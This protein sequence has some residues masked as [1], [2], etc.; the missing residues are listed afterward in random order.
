MKIF[1]FIV[2]IFVLVG[3]S[4]NSFKNDKIEGTIHFS[5]DD[6]NAVFK[7]LTNNKDKYNSLF[8]QSFFRYLR[9]LHERYDAKVTLYCFY[10]FND[11][12]L[13]DCTTKYS[14]EFQSCSDWLKL[15]YHAYNA[16]DIFNGGGYQKFID[17]VFKITGSKQCVSQTVRLD[18]FLGEY[19]E[20]SENSF[21]K[22][23]L[24][25]KQLLTADSKTRHSY[26][27]SEEAQKEIANFEKWND[28][29]NSIDFYVTD[30]RFD[31]YKEFPNLLNENDR[32]K[33]IVVFTHEWLLFFPMRK[34]L[35]A[36]FQK[37]Y[38]AKRIKENINDCF[39]HLMKEG[40]VFTTEF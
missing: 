10:D 19:K 24:G 25:I 32:E 16:R 4:R 6:V 20:I 35:L 29:S 5:I 30:F 13:K 36:Y 1:C 8:E 12:C 7:D 22:N 15:G 40:Y 14:E 34:N 37:I 18:R 39:E 2:F 21:E 3:C 26:Y 27:L 33:E 23:P 38:K 11:F 9:N 31:D 17:A 28:S